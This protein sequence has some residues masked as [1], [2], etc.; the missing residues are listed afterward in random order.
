MYQ[1]SS[2]LVLGAF[3]TRYKEH[4]YELAALVNDVANEKQYAVVIESISE[5]TMYL[6]K[7]SRSTVFP[8]IGKLSRNSHRRIT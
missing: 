6:Q 8:F 4:R 1:C 7:S 2:V 3:R 5:Y